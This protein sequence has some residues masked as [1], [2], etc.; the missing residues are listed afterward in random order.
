MHQP[1]GA[2]NLLPR[3]PPRIVWMPEKRL[4]QPCAAQIPPSRASSR[5]AGSVQHAFTPWQVFWLASWRCRLPK[6]LRFASLSGSWQPLLPLGDSQQRACAGLSPASLFT[7]SRR[8]HDN[9]KLEKKL[10]RTAPGWLL[11]APLLT[12][13]Y[14]KP[15]LSPF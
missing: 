9:A 2:V 1:R 13:L 5:S 15:R 12:F 4:R 8:H 3:R 10:L 6:V 11:P 7:A 14:C